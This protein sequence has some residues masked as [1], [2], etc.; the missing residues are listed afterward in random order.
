M[1]YRQPEEFQP[2]RTAESKQS[3]SR[4]RSA[5]IVVRLNE[6]QWLAAREEATVWE[7]SGVH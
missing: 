2:K 5:P 7:E 4:N 3:N 6:N 1:T